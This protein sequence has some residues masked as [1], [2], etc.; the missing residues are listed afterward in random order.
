MRSAWV[1]ILTWAWAGLNECSPSRESISMRGIT[2]KYGM[3]GWVVGVMA[4]EIGNLSLL[5]HKVIT[6][7]RQ[8]GDERYR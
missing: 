6:A 2:S 7:W 8:V 5:H 1:D 4:P 3:K